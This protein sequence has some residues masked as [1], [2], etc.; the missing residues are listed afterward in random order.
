MRQSKI[1][2]HIWRG[3]NKGVASGL[4]FDSPSVFVTAPGQHSH[5]LRHCH[6]LPGH[7]SSRSRDTLSNKALMGAPRRQRRFSVTQLLSVNVFRL[8]H[9]DIL[10][11]L[12]HF[13]MCYHLQN[14]NIFIFIFNIKYWGFGLEQMGKNGYQALYECNWTHIAV[15]RQSEYFLLTRIFFA[16]FCFPR[17][18]SLKCLFDLWTVLE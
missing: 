16:T 4:Q 17:V 12:P 13:D 9:L 2:P 11:I 15:S 6:T 8:L 18:V 5:T 7:C 14:I 1:N 10:S 3:L